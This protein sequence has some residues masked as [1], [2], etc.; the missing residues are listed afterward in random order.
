MKIHKEHYRI[1]SII[2]DRERERVRE[3]HDEEDGPRRM[4]KKGTDMGVY[5]VKNGALSF[6]IKKQH[7]PCSY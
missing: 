3:R 1:E 7:R 6:S 2:R 5:E 4:A